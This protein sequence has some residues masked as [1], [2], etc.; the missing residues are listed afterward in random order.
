MAT[1]DLVCRECKKEFSV[2]KFNPNYPRKYCDTCSKKRKELWEKRH[3]VKFED[4]D[5]D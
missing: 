3:L 1:K 5:D 2:E 4:C